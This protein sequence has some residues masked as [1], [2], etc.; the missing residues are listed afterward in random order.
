MMRCRLLT[1]G[2]TALCNHAAQV[3]SSFKARAIKV[4]RISRVQTRVL[5][6]TTAGMLAGGVGCFTLAGLGL[7]YMQQYMQS[8]E[9]EGPGPLSS[10]IPKPD[11]QVSFNS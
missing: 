9:R 11:R 1:I 6:A 4:S 5:L 3:C 10:L 7:Q 8:S 2:V